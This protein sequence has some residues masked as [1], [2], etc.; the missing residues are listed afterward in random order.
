M[1]MRQAA[2]MA[3]TSIEIIQYLT[4]QRR[5]YLKMAILDAMR[6]QRKEEPMGNVVVMQTS[7]TTD[8]IMEI[9]ANGFAEQLIEH[10]GFYKNF[11]YYIESRHGVTEHRLY[12]D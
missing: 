1:S 9:T 4:E 7:R 8:D 6:N 10:G 3:K 11:R 5:H 2:P 12:F